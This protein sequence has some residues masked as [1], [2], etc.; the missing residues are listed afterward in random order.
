MPGPTHLLLP[1]QLH[2]GKKTTIISSIISSFLYSGTQ[3][4]ATFIENIWNTSMFR[5]ME[6]PEILHMSLWSEDFG[7]MLDTA[8]YSDDIEFKW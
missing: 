7:A 8:M 3:D 4:I 5:D 6:I 1:I 2:L